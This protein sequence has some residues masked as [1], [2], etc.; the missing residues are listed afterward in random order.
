MVT[1]VFQA[2]V[3]SPWAETSAP[4]LQ[5][6]LFLPNGSSL[7]QWYEA[8]FGLPL[9]WPEITAMN[10][11]Y[12]HPVSP[13]CFHDLRKCEATR[14]Q[15]SYLPRSQTLCAAET[16]AKNQTFALSYKRDN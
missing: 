10:P 7:D 13:Y 3:A 12:M 9:S 2:K 14:L 1:G 8:V 4:R 11:D 16:K 6:S 5:V 15:L